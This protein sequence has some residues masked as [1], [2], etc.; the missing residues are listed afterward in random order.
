[1]PGLSTP[2]LMGG[3]PPYPNRGAGLVARV[4]NLEKSVFG[5]VQSGTLT[6]R[7]G[8][9]ESKLSIPKADTASDLPSRVNRIAVAVN[10]TGL[11]GQ[12]DLTNEAALPQSPL[13]SPQVGSLDAVDRALVERLRQLDALVRIQRGL[14]PSASMPSSALPSSRSNGSS[15][16]PL[17]SDPLDPNNSTASSQATATP[18]KHGFLHGLGKVVSKAGGMVLDTM[19][20]PS[21]MPGYG[22][23][24]GGFGSPGLGGLG[25]LGGAGMYSGFGPGA[26][27]VPG[28]YMT[29]GPYGSMF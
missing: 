18:A 26:A 25:G 24:Y 12:S 17:A 6:E 22:S 4:S 16:S 29:R 28:M 27:S 10:G 8:G 11:S 15:N 2:N 20:G 23:G 21:F 1:M 9:L 5:T 14:P 13:D 3:R 19:A 7:I